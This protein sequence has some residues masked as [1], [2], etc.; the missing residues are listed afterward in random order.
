MRSVTDYHQ[1]NILQVLNK[2]VLN[3]GYNLARISMG[4]KRTELAI[5]TGQLNSKMTNCS[6]GNNSD[7][8]SAVKQALHEDADDAIISL[9]TC[10]SDMGP[11][12]KNKSKGSGALEVDQ[13]P[14]TQ[15]RQVGKH[16]YSVT[17]QSAAKQSDSIILRLP[18]GRKMMY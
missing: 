15:T 11:W 14:G 12:L 9:I 5:A 2:F 1:I 17:G 3:T 18:M 13:R 4:Q 16:C 8:C 6:F 7:P 10:T